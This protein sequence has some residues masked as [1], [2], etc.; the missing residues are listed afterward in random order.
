MAAYRADEG[1]DGAGVLGKQQYALLDLLSAIIFKRGQLGEGSLPDDFEAETMPLTKRQ[2]ACSFP[3]A[4][5]VVAVLVRARSLCL[6][7][8]RR[9]VCTSLV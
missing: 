8:E 4:L 2:K 7:Y 5:L 9:S 6:G 1:R 3:T